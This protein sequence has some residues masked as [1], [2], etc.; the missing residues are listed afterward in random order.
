MAPTSIVLADDHHVV[1]QGLRALLEAAPDLVVVGE[2]ADAADAVEM[3]VR[4]APDV[5]ILDLVM[6]GNGLQALRRI[7]QEAPR[8]RVIVLSM[9]ASEAYVVEALKG[10]ASAYVVK[11]ATASD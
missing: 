10:G 4:L 11:D 8:T 7:A 3:T 5:L 9:H 1:R 2:A 6:I